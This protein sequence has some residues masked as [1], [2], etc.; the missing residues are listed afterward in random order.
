[1][2]STDPRAFGWM[3]ANDDAV[4]SYPFHYRDKATG[5]PLEIT[6]HPYV[7]IADSSYAKQAAASGNSKYAKDLLP[8]CGGD[9]SDPYTFD[10]AH[11]PSIGYVPYMVTGDFYYLEELQFAASYV[12]LW[13]N[14]AYR[15]YSKGVLHHAQP[16][17]RGQAWALRTLSDAAFITPDSDPMKCYFTQLMTNILSDYNTNYTDGGLTDPLHIAFGYFP[18]TI[19]GQARD[20]IAPWQDDFFTWA[21][22][23]AA[24]QGFPGAAK[25][26]KWKAAFQV[27]MMEG[28][29][30]DATHGYCWL[31]ASAYKVQ[32]RDSQS[33]PLYSNLTKVYQTTFPN[34]YGLTCNT[35]AMVNAMSSSSHTYQLGEMRGYAWSPTGYPSNLQIGLAMAA[36]SGIPGAADAWQLFSNRSVKPDYG[37]YPN[38]AVIPRN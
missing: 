30:S 6:N 3:L 18:Y 34:L 38:F 33:A 5:R 27:G 14:P 15:Q 16:Q 17:V 20:G 21:V 23:H 10:I 12:E 13:P 29:K 26:L 22:G 31:E 2:I 24:E 1:V 28:W 19:N 25:L 4:G 8:A 11:H 9:C 32:V 37:N 7:T 36:E 35:Q